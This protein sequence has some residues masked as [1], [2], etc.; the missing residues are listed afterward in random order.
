VDSLIKFF[1][2]VYL[3]NLESDEAFAGYNWTT[4]R[5]EEKKISIKH[6]VKIFFLNAFSGKNVQQCF[7]FLNLACSYCVQ[8]PKPHRD[9][10]L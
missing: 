1:L 9:G 2:K 7:F 3:W 8:E 4:T 5:P 6:I 10:N